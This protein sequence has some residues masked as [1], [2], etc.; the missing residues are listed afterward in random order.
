MDSITRGRTLDSR[1]ARQQ[2][3]WGYALLWLLGVPIPILLV[4]YL[5]RGCS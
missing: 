5:L 1:P 4:I 3:K 2:G